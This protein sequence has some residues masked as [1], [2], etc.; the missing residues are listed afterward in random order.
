MDKLAADLSSLNLTPS[1]DP[2]GVINQLKLLLQQGGVQQP[3][4]QHGGP[5]H[6]SHPANQNY[7]EVLQSLSNLFNTP[8]QSASSKPQ[9]VPQHEETSQARSDPYVAP[10]TI[11]PLLTPKTRGLESS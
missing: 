2:Q 4:E 9:D 8:N 6:G 7:S 3:S 1:Q 10:P 5:P 11:Q